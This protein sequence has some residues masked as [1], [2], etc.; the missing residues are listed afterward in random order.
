MQKTTT[1]RFSSRFHL[2][3]ASAFLSKGRRRGWPNVRPGID[4]N[5]DQSLNPLDRLGMLDAETFGVSGG[6]HA[7]LKPSLAR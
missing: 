7:G 5:S 2:S 6:K 1:I 3:C 4:V